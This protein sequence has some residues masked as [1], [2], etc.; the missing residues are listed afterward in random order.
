LFA[1]RYPFPFPTDGAVFPSASLFGGGYRLLGAAVGMDLD[2]VD[3]SDDLLEEGSIWQSTYV[4]SEGMLNFNE[5]Y[6]GDFEGYP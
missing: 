1:L 6:S 4:A 5:G 3:Y 2:A